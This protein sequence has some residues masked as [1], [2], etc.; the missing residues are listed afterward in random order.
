M[1][2]VVKSSFSLDFS[3]Y[4]KP[5]SIKIYGSLEKLEFF[6]YYLKDGKVIG[7]SSVNADPVAADFANTL[8]EGR[9]LTEEEINKDPF[10][11]MT[12]KPKD[13]SKRFQESSLVNVQA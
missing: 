9:T 1:S 13:A 12:N 11:W 3:G 7:M 5:T 2:C 8:Y 4:G 6:A 10:G